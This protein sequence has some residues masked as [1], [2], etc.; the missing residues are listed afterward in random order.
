ML[1]SCIMRSSN[2][3]R[4][5]IT[6]E[7]LFR[8]ASQ[9]ANVAYDAAEHGKVE[10]YPYNGAE[11][12]PDAWIKGEGPAPAYERKKRPLICDSALDLVGN[13]PMVR[14][15]RLAES[16]DLQNEILA[17]CE[18]FSAGGSIKDRIALRMIEDAEKEGRIKPGDILIEPTSGNTGIGMCL[19]AAVKGYHM[20]ITM[21]KKMSGEKINTMQALGAL[22]LRTENSKAWNDPESHIGLAIRLQKTFE[23]AHILDQYLN[24]GNP[25]AHYDTTAEEILE[26]TEGKID[27]AFISAGT[28]GT[29]TGIARKLK[30]KVPGITIIGIDPY[31]SILALPDSLNDKSERTGHQ[32]L[33]VYHVEGIGYDFIPTSLD[34]RVV[35]EW[36]KTDD[37]ESFAMALKIIEH[38]GLLCGGSSGSAMAGC[39]RYLKDRKIT[40]KRCVVVLPDGTRNYMSKFLCPEWRATVNLS[41]SG[42]KDF[43]SNYPDSK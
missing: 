39:Y 21:P 29:I 16:L 36:L 14:V 18:F 19:A 33:E 42:D 34:R 38:E 28:G 3:L 35:D 37:D 12:A 5:T 4:K 31:G 17:K 23:N 10:P 15:T 26:Q 8:K 1:M 25:L 13:T 41:A 22:I 11:N 30:E 27:Y 20:I 40:G 6:R 32:R 24:P 9:I 43:F 2:V 7:D